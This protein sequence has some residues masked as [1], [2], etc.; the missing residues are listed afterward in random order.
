MYV[1]W[2]FHRNIQY[3]K[4]RQIVEELSQAHVETWKVRVQF[5]APDVLSSGGHEAASQGVGEEGRKGPVDS[6]APGPGQG[7]GHQGHQQVEPD[8]QHQAT[9][10]TKVRSTEL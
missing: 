4:K 3:W 9:H 10:S 6:E 5:S 7:G 1:H 2:C 8:P